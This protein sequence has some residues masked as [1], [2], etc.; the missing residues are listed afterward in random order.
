MGAASGV[1]MTILA[2]AASAVRA[3]GRAALVALAVAVP[4]VGATLDP[5]ALTG[6][7]P[8][9]VQ[10]SAAAKV[11]IV[12]YA[13]LT[14]SHCAAFHQETWPSLKKRYVDT[15]KVKFV[16]REFPLDPLAAAGFMLARC[17]GP[18]RRDGLIDL[19]FDQQKNWAFSPKPAEPLLTL[20]KQA[21]MSQTDFET[22]LQN[23]ELYNSVNKSRD[24]AAARLA[25]EST[26]TFFVNGQKLT[27]E[28]PIGEFEKVLT[29]LLK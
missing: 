10:G 20:V 26:P 14:C 8:D 5:L 22:C 28:Q 15:G 13:S 2:F 27:G 12:E 1:N 18:D 29:P 16:L 11:T 19:M 24:L 25:I 17:L 6:P 3:L 21:G 7:L 9:I 4:A 23:Q